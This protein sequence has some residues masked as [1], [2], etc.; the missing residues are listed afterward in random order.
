[1]NRLVTG[2]DKENFSIFE[3]S[4]E[5]SEGGLCVIFDMSGSMSSKIG[6]AREAVYEKF[7]KTAN[8]RTS[9]S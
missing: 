4:S 9:S 6:N 2:L 8:R 1:M 5:A 3:G 7:F